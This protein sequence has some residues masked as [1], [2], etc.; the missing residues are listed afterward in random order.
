MKVGGGKFKFTGVT[1]GG[2]SRDE[3][4]GMVGGVTRGTGSS[5]GGRSGVDNG[6]SNHGNASDGRVGSYGSD[7]VAV[8]MSRSTI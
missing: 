5:T 2:D 7:M 8:V 6:P 3:M 1:D 4:S